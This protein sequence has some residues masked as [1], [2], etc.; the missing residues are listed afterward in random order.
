[1]PQKH[2]VSRDFQPI[3]LFL[4]DSVVVGV[5]V[6]N[7]SAFASSLRPIVLQLMRYASKRVLSEAIALL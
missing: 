3:Q 6:F 4:V 7:D 5:D 2:N 1:M